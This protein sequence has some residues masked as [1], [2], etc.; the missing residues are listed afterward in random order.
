MSRPA[1]TT[2]TGHVK[3]SS[4]EIPRLT[5]AAVA[6]VLWDATCWGIRFLRRV[7]KVASRLYRLLSIL[8]AVG[9]EVAKM[10]L[11]VIDEILCNLKRVARD[12]LR[13]WLE[14]ILKFMHTLLHPV[15]A[16][17]DIAVGVVQFRTRAHRSIS[18]RR[19][20]IQVLKAKAAA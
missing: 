7:W 8:D 15:R 4:V 5:F 20:S 9:W 1:E 3:N 19:S 18:V 14:E 2:A 10:L 11:A 12:F 6:R 17:P 16:I 13:L